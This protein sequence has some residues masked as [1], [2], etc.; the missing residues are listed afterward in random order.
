MN[1]VGGGGTL[2]PGVKCPTGQDTVP[3]V[4]CPR[5]QDKPEGYILPL[6]KV[7]SETRYYVVSCLRGQ[8]TGGTR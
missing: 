1:G 6:G 3:T 2:Y 4:S 7:S 5:G 8:D